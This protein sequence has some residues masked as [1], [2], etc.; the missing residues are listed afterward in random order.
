M[1]IF[2]GP[3][4][5]MVPT[6]HSVPFR[7]VEKPTYRRGL[8]DRRANLNSLLV[9][10]ENGSRSHRVSMDGKVYWFLNW[11]NNISCA[12]LV[13]LGRDHVYCQ[14]HGLL[15]FGSSYYNDPTSLLIQGC[16]YVFGFS[17]LLLCGVSARS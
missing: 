1:F 6:E 11:T 9:C 12:D 2:L 15:I 8:R 14:N 16:F 4:H 10:V 7:V 17:I 3:N 5:G 13:S